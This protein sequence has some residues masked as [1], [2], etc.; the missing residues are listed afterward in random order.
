MIKY[1]LKC[2]I[3]TGISELKKR[4]SERRNL[5]RNEVCKKYCSVYVIC[6]ECSRS[7]GTRGGN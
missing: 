6:Y 7:A 5:L 3:K 4:A 1:E 2:N